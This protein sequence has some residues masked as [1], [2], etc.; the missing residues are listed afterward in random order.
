MPEIHTEPSPE[1]EQDAN[2]ALA[3]RTEAFVAEMKRVLERERLLADDAMASWMSA[4][5]MQINILQNTCKT[6]T[7][8]DWARYRSSVEAL[9]RSA[10]ELA[11]M[12]ASVVQHRVAAPPRLAVVS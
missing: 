9:H 2:D 7:P 6:L 3:E 10:A 8:A 12:L 11:E 4:S 5:A 1:K